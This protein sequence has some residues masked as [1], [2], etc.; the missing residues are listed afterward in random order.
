MA[1]ETSWNRWAIRLNEFAQQHWRRILILRDRL[2]MSE[3]AVSVVAAVVVGVIGGFTNLAYSMVNQLTKW[4]L[5][6]KTGDLVEI[7]RELLAHPG[8]GFE[9]TG[10]HRRLC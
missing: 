5:L 10:F 7:A 2:R 6:G 1:R 4:L 3:E 9:L 8:A